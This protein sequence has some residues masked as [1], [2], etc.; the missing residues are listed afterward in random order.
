M[1]YR[2]RAVFG[3]RDF[4][5]LLLKIAPTKTLMNYELDSRSNKRALV[6]IDLANIDWHSLNM[7]LN[8][9]Q[10][11]LHEAWITFC[12]QKMRNLR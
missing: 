8:E 9:K 7:R 5:W 4:A 6:Q 10:A 12:I 3:Q 11:K 1:L 2:A